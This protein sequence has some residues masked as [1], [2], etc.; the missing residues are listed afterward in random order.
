MSLKEVGNKIAAGI[1]KH[2]D[3][4]LT[5][6]ALLGL[7][8]TVFLA[9]KETPAAL[10]ILDDAKD[11]IDR[12]D[13]AVEDERMDE[14][15]AEEKIKK[16]KTDAAKKLVINYLP[17]GIS[18]VGTSACIIG[19][20]KVSRSRNAALSGALNAANIAYNEYRDHVREEIGEKKENKIQEDIRKEHVEAYPP[21]KVERI[22]NTG[23]GDTLCH[24]E[25]NPGNPETGIYFYS[26][27]EAIMR[28]I[29]EANMEG[30]RSCYVSMQDLLWYM[31]LN[32]KGDGVSLIGWNMAKEAE[33][34]EP[35][36]SSFLYN[37][38]PVLDI[39]FYN[40]PKPNFASFG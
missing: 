19:S 4:I 33:L 16:V 7:G 30:M 10:D 11:S 22:Y 13:K 27:P 2:A 40:N 36:R 1:N 8:T 28:A 25:T 21:T 12:I 24:I 20:N 31:G 18:F 32:V 39:S 29:N 38:R 6:S 17:A 35:R 3:I 5:G 9:V 15:D 34:I 14:Y 26:S 23:N 37:D